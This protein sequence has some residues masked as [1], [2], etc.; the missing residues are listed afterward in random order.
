MKRR[1]KAEQ[2]GQSRSKETLEEFI[3][4]KK[5]DVEQ[6]A[7]CKGKE[8]KEESIENKKKKNTEQRAKSRANIIPKLYEARSAQQVLAGTQIVNELK[9]TEDDIGRMDQRCPECNALKWKNENPT[10]CCKKGKISLPSFP[11]PLNY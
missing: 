9:N 2:K 8:T 5:K 3:K 6:K 10:I 1:L 7:K 11:K 4:R